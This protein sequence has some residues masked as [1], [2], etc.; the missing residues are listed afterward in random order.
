VPAVADGGAAAGLAVDGG[1][2]TVVV[3][4]AGAGVAAG[5]A[6]LSGAVRA[7][8]LV[9]GVVLW[10]RPACGGA[11]AL[12]PSCG[13]VEVPVCEGGGA[14]AHVGVRTGREVAAGEMCLDRGVVTAL[15]E[16]CGGGEWSLPGGGVLAA[17]R[18][19]R[20]S[21]RGGAAGEAV[22]AREEGLAH[23]LAAA[24]FEGGPDGTRVL[25]VLSALGRIFGL[26]VQDGGRVLWAVD[27]DGAAGARLIL[28][29]GHA[30]YA[31][32]VSAG[33]GKTSLLTV[34]AATGDTLDSA[35]LDGFVA[36]Q[37]S[38]PSPAS[39]C[40][41]LL[42]AAG[43]ERRGGPECGAGRGAGLS[44]VSAARGSDR[45]VGYQA[46]ALV[47][48]A[49][50]P[51]GGRVLD[52]AA[53]GAED[54]FSFPPQAAPVRVTGDRKVLYKHVDPSI[55]LVL[56]ANA[57]ADGTTDEARQGVS[58][59]LVNTLTGAVVDA[60][61]HPGG[62][63]PVA[64]IRCDNWF[65]Y[66]FWNA[67]V[68]EQELHVVDMYE[69]LPRPPWMRRAI[70]GYVRSVLRDLL[71]SA[72]SSEALHDRRRAAAAA[73]TCSALSAGCAFPTAPGG[74]DAD[75]LDPASSLPRLVRT[76]FLLTHAVTSL[77]V[78]VSERGAT[79]RGV[80]LGLS[81][82]R[83]VHLPRMTLDP[84]RPARESKASIDEMLR[85]YWPTIE[86]WPTSSSGRLYVNGG[87]AVPGLLATGGLVTSPVLGRESSC[88]FAAIGTDIVYGTLS[89]A[90]AFDALSDDFDYVAVVS[91]LALLTLAVAASRRAAKRRLLEDQW[92]R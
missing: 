55:A 39:G 80:I 30:R 18:R 49:G 20:L 57:G 81:S 32:V 33:G 10:E 52:M 11:V 64:A 76:S 91:T 53:T 90:G 28:V 88:H 46:G 13:V 85:P 29:R 67:D 31:F 56:S 73:G 43:T 26:D 16:S 14:P 51:A 27:V 54:P 2:G 4:V 92:V 25:L 36:E 34:L 45:L 74:A 62:A 47:W 58:A 78:T 38:L 87:G 1:S 44:W 75:K 6:P 68:L 60:V 9:S 77:G 69:S 82:G 42:D 24:F 22:W 21:Y 86:L 12:L 17:S 89:P 61:R 35:V 63:E 8:D 5:E 23:G 50:L 84:R 19:G 70:M 72:V 3:V 15:A 79:D 66:T 40:V 59:T 65:V 71:P 83:I 7:L 41:H 37:A 48:E